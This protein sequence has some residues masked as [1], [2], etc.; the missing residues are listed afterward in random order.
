MRKTVQ[1]AEWQPEDKTILIKLFQRTLLCPQ[2]FFMHYSWISSG[3]ALA[4]LP[5]RQANLLMILVLLPF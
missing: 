4:N 2:Y 3:L 1:G 5:M